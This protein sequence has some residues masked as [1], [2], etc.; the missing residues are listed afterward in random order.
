MKYVLALLLTFPISSVAQQAINHEAMHGW[1]F[2]LGFAGGSISHYRGSDQNYLLLFP[3]PTIFY[4]GERIKLNRSGGSVLLTT[5][6][7]FSLDLSFA[8]GIPVTSA[9]NIARLG[10]QDI[11]PNLELGPGAHWGIWQSDDR[12]YQW[13]VSAPL[14]AAINLKTGN[15]EG[16]T[17]SPYIQFRHLSLFD[18]RLSI[19]PIWA[20]ESYHDIYYQVDSPYVTPNRPGYDA[21]AGYSGF[22]TTLTSSYWLSPKLW[23]V[24]AIRYDTLSGAVFADSPL[25]KQEDSLIIGGNIFYFF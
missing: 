16:Y 15:E 7:Q 19:G 1:D 20:S 5:T 24:G 12:K 14:R 3:Y 23:L 25:V 17:F 4:T 8:L 21:K 18:T 6:E 11:A 22:R 10:M 13:T 2:G 9:G